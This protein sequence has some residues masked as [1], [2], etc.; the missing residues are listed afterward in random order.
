MESHAVGTPRL[1]EPMP[2]LT[3]RPQTEQARVAIGRGTELCDRNTTHALLQPGHQ[4]GTNFF[5]RGPQTESQNPR[6][7]TT[8]KTEIVPQSEH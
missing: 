1:L 6:G 8:V 5:G 4:W 3:E 7:H 2:C